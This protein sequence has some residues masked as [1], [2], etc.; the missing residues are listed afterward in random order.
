MKNHWEREWDRKMAAHDAKTK[1]VGL[2]C[3]AWMLLCLL[4]WPL[5]VYLGS[6]LVALGWRAAGK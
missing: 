1:R 4:L 5:F 3:A 2:M 6:Y